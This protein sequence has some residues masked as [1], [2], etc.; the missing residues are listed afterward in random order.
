MFTLGWQQ[1]A[2]LHA[3][4]PCIQMSQHVNA[5]LPVLHQ[6]NRASCGA[7][8]KRL[9]SGPMQLEEKLLEQMLQ[10]ARAAEDEEPETGDGCSGKE[11]ADEE[12]EDI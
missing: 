8:P 6:H 10:Q 12:F 4:R 2:M 1:Q 7:L 5:A 9:L 11:P 3:H